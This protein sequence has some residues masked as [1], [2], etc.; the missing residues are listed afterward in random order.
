MADYASLI[1]PT[2]LLL[3]CGA[4][5]D[6]CRWRGLSGEALGRDLP[7][8]TFFHHDPH[9]VAGEGVPWLHVRIL[10]VAYGKC[11]AG[12]EHLPRRQ[13]VNVIDLVGQVD[14][15]VVHFF[16]HFA[17][18]GGISAVDVDAESIGREERRRGLAVALIDRLRPFRDDAFYRLL[19][20]IVGLLLHGS[21]GHRGTERQD[22]RR[23][24]R[25]YDWPHVSLLFVYDRDGNVFRERALKR[26]RLVVDMGRAL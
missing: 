16:G 22:R 7:V 2:V 9:P 20:L 5:A 26:E 1:H 10:A 12:Q 23:D 13:E 3:V 21:G 8:G 15:H 24:R 18:L 14:A 6:R 4:R 19:R 11:A 25:R 17:R